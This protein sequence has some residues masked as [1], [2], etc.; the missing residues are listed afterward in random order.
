MRNP[1]ALLCLLL[2]GMGIAL[3]GCRT[4]Q[5]AEKTKML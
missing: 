3:T 1:K 4:A 2:C 5:R